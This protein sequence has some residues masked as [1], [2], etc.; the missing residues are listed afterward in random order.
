LKEAVNEIRRASP[1]IWEADWHVLRTLA[2]A[3]RTMLA[4]RR[5]Q[6]QGA[7]VIDFGCGNRPYESWFTAAGAHYQGADIRDDAEVRV[8]ADGTLQASDAQYDLVAS[9]QVLEHVWDVGTYLREARRVL[10]RDGWLLLSTHGTWLYHPH[11]NDYRRWT[12]EG[13]RREVEAQGFRLVRICPVV[14]PLAWTTV[15]RSIGAAQL[16]R[17]LPVVGTLVW[18]VLA[19]ALNICAWVEDQMT[20]EHITANNACVYVGL[21]SRDT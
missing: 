3:I 21:F 14:G 11:P 9:F 18:P 10:K 16:L 19:V 20:P 15:F 7:R 17:R 12:A 5:L 2:K 13:L 8:L 4:D 6:L 1:H